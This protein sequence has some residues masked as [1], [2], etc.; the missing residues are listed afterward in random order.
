MILDGGLI[1][2]HGGAMALVTSS[3]IAGLLR[4]NP[5]LF[6]K[7]FPDKLRATQPPLSKR[8]TVVGTLL[9]LP[10]F[11]ALVGFPVWSAL[12]FAGTGADALSIWSHAFLVGMT[13]NLVDWLVLDELCLGV[14]KPRWALPPGAT[15]AEALPFEHGRHFADFLKGV[16][17]FAVVAALAVGI[18]MLVRPASSAGVV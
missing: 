7:H 9:G 1:L 11:A 6:L 12:E 16:I 2:M 8:E 13:A 5:R 18:V 17:L 10:L 4:H 15:W 3:I 14:G